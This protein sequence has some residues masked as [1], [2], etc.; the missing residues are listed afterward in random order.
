MKESELMPLVDSAFANINYSIR[1]EVRFKMLRL[2]RVASLGGTAY[3]VEA[4][5]SS[6][7]SFQNGIRQLLTLK[8][9]RFHMRTEELGILLIAVPE[10]KV[11]MRR[12]ANDFGISCIDALGLQKV[13]SYQTQRPIAQKKDSDVPF[14]EFANRMISNLTTVDAAKQD[15]GSHVQLDFRLVDEPA[16]PNLSPVVR[17]WRSAGE[18]F[19]ASALHGVKE[20][21]VFQRKP[22]RKRTKMVDT[23]EWTAYQDRLSQLNLKEIG[24][25]GASAD[26]RG[27]HVNYSS[28]AKAADVV[29]KLAEVVFGRIDSVA[30]TASVFEIANPLSIA[31]GERF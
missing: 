6:T 17:V 10:L 26:G 24:D 27:V 9:Q 3:F 15:Q 5:G 2:D 29:A 8:D 12:T 11:G 25:Q 18:T 30:L 23:P 14:I 13:A 28:V 4:E 31:Y 21:F 19:G 1:K 20:V 22:G 7:R 16:N